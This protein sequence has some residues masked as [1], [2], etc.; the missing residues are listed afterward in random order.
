MLNNPNYLPIFTTNL[1][2]LNNI[3]YAHGACCETSADFY[4]KKGGFRL[5]NHILTI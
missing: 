2:S 3:S 4:T 1:M 5:P